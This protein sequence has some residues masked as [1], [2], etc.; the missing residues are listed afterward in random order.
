MTRKTRE[1]GFVVGLALLFAVSFPAATA[2]QDAA[3]RVTGFPRDPVHVAAWPNG[4][5]HPL[6]TN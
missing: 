2:A 5:K 1:L 4:R 3:D 6:R